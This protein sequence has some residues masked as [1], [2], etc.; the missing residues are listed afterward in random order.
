MRTVVGVLLGLALLAPAAQA[1]A[2][3][4]TT[5]RGDPTRDNRVTGAPEPGLGVLWARDFGAAVSYRGG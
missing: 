1:A 5:Y 2:P 4:T 3:A